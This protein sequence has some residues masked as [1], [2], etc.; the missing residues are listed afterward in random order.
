TALRGVLADT[1][2]PAN[3]GCNRQLTLIFPEGSILNPRRGAP[4]RARATTCCRALD[5]VHDALAKVMPERVPA[6]GANSTTGFF[7]AHARPGGGIAIHLD[8]LCGGWGAAK[9]YDAIR[10]TDHVLSSC[11]LT[12]TEAVEQINRHV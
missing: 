11:R 12:P 5:A 6:E 9:G 1:G 8:V 10:A 3:D 7:L 4:V 2:M